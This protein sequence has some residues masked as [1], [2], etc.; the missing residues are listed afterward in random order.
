MA[1]TPDTID[2]LFLGTGTSTGLPL[3]PC[4]TRTD[5]YPAGFARH[6]PLITPPNNAQLPAGSYDPEGEWPDN[7]PCACCRSAVS[8]TV[9]EGWK[10]RRGNTSVVVRKHHAGRVRNVVVDVGKTFKEQTQRFF[11]AW[12][13]ESIDAVILTHGRESIRVAELTPRCGRL[14][15]PG[16]STGM[17]STAT[18]DYT[19]IP[20]QGDVCNGGIE[21]SIPS[22]QE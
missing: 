12:G 20:Q 3:V 7:I 22:R 14:L 10:N 11:P 15:W 5:D 2:L 18:G 6:V 19:D 16:R 1:S 21:L 17:V 8:E 13:I 9:P 4:L